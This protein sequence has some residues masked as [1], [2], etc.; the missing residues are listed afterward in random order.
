MSEQPSLLTIHIANE[1]VNGFTN[2]TADA[3]IDLHKEIKAGPM[4]L[5]GYRV[6]ADTQAHALSQRLV[7]VSLPFVNGAN[8]TDELSY[9]NC[10]PLMLDNAQVT[11]KT[12]MNNELQIT[13]DIPR[14]FKA[15]CLNRDGTTV[16]T[17]Q[18]LAVTLQFSYA[19]GV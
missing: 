14:L 1:T 18:I 7:Y 17:G 9:Q 4:Y 2:T 11:L 3:T 8:L 12:E 13:Q 19:L 10:L 16:S 5:R 15:K 6:E